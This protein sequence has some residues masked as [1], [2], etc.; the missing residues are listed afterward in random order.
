[1]Y[2]ITD[3]QRTQEEIEKLNRK[4]K[5]LGCSPVQFEV[6]RSYTEKRDG[7][8]VRVYEVELA[9]QAPRL[10]GWVFVA[11]LVHGV[12]DGANVIKSI[13]DQDLPE[14]YRKVQQQC[15]HCQQNRNRKDTYIVQNEES[16]EYKQVGSTCLLDFLG[17]DPEKALKDIR[18][19]CE[20]EE[21]MDSALGWRGPAY[22]PI[23]VFLE[24]VVAEIRRNGWVSRS[25]AR[26][27]YTLLATADAVLND[28]GELKPDEK[29][30]AAAAA[31]L[32]WIRSQEGDLNEYM[33]NLKVACTDDA[34]L[35]DECA[36]IVASLIPTYQRE[37]AR[38]TDG[39][40]SEYQGEIGNR[41]E[42][43]LALDSIRHIDG[44]YG[45][46]ILHTFSDGNGNIFVWFSSSAELEPGKSYHGK[47]TVKDH[48]EY[49]GVQQTILTR[50]K[51][52]EAQ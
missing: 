42:W 1:M 27:D 52:Q 38:V 10:A 13:A 22:L 18:L 4:A 49:R 46:S 47:A 26:D 7:E 41:R 29:D 21:I 14:K 36:G 51:F 23:E 35:I 45:V 30:V 25:R 39:G 16:G 40:G 17:H 34:M 43:S 15:D 33:W 20:A 5:R 50:C 6:I 12:A 44:Y 31:A 28:K 48:K 2:Q 37:T 8:I 24:R 11:K 32:Q 9:G 3:L 19:W